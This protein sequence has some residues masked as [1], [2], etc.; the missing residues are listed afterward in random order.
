[1]YAERAK[2]YEQKAVDILTSH[3]TLVCTDGISLLE[4]A[5]DAADYLDTVAS[6]TPTLDTFYTS[7]STVNT[8][9]TL[10][11]AKCAIVLSEATLL[12]QNYVK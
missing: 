4:K 8:N 1:M 2:S 5:Q 10:G 7:L 12:L 6:V 9:L 3:E 11:S